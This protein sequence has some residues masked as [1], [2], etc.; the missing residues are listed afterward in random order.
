MHPFATDIEKLDFLL[1]ATRRSCWRTWRPRRP[2]ARSGR[3]TSRA[4]SAPSR[5]W[6][7]GSGGTR[8]RG[9]RASWTPSAGRRSWRTCTRRRACGSWPTTGCG[10]LLGDRESLTTAMRNAAVRP[11]STAEAPSIRIRRF[12]S[13]S[14]SSTILTHR[15]AFRTERLRRGPAQGLLTDALQASSYVP[16]ILGSLLNAAHPW[17]GSYG[18]LVCLPSRSLRRAWGTTASRTAL[19]L[20]SAM[21]Y[22]CVRYRQYPAAFGCKSALTRCESGHRQASDRFS[23]PVERAIMGARRVSALEEAEFRY[24]PDARRAPSPAKPSCR[25]ILLRE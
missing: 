10:I 6:W 12:E 14:V 7:I 11:S 25:T 21:R 24:G 15:N 18:T 9:L 4:T 23:E 1:E 3:S 20:F 19:S 13:R 2:T 22:S 17:M 8:P 5:S 16:H